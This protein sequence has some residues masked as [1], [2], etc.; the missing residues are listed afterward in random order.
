M[1]KSGNWLT[2]IAVATKLTMLARSKVR[3]C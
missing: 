1:E 2:E 3:E